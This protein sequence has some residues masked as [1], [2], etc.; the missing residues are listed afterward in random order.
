MNKSFTLIEILVVIVVIG[1][2]SAFILVGISSINSS[3][4]IAKGQAFTN[5]MRN[6]LLLSLISEWKFE[7]NANDSWGAN[8]GTISGAVLTSSGCV[9]GSCYN[10]DSTDYIEILDSPALRLSN[11]GTISMWAYP[12]VVGPG[13]G[14][15][16]TTDVNGSNGYLLLPCFTNNAA[17]FISGPYLYSLGNAV[18][19]NRWSLITVTFNS[20]GRKMYVNGVDSTSSGGGETALPPANPS[21][22][23]NIRIGNRAGATDRI[24]DGMIDEVSIYDTVFSTS[25]VQEKYY[26]GINKLLVNNSFGQKE[27]SE[28]LSQLKNNLANDN[29]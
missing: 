11:G 21:P 14:I 17:I 27:Y 29:I 23:P 22:V 10:F 25:Q 3:A 16:K 5:S 7:G 6:S 12:R 20:S 28:R 24:F 26:S 18:S 9:K 15:D 13:R 2:L 1:V 4:N 8:N 19:L